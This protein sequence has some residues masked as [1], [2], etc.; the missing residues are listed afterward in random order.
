MYGYKD[1]LQ[2]VEVIRQ[3]AKKFNCQLTISKDSEHS[4]MNNSDRTILQNWIKEYI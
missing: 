2:S 3:F 1:T 4:F